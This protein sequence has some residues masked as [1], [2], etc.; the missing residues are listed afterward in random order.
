MSDITTIARPYA[1]AALQ[2]AVANEEINAWSEMFQAATSALHDERVNFLLTDPRI[3]INEK[4]ELLKNICKPWLDQARENFLKIVGHYHR[5]EFLPE[6]AKLY[7]ELKAAWQK[8]LVV[9]VISAFPLQKEQKEKLKKALVIR[10]QKKITLDCSVEKNLIGG[11]IIQAGDQVIDNSV[12][13]QLER[14]SQ[15]ILSV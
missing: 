5:L 9:N 7:E 13:G 14:M 15:V 3:T 1:K 2:Y 8:E 12:S 10:F 6:I 4:V 11:V